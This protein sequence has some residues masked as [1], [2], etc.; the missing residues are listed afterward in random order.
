MRLF[1]RDEGPLA[2]LAQEVDN[3]EI[4]LLRA[5]VTL[6]KHFRDLGDTRPQAKNKVN[7]LIQSLASESFLYTLGI[8]TPLSSGVNGSS[9]AFMDQAAKDTFIN[10]L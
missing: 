1:K 9:L 6:R 7:Q 4:K 3:N 2:K 8:D 10:K 5:I